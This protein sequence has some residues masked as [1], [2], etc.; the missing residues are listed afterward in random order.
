ML[1]Y[2]LTL[3]G[4]REPQFNTDFSFRYYFGPGSLANLQMWSVDT[5]GM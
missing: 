5:L 4:K 1:I 2:F 3:R